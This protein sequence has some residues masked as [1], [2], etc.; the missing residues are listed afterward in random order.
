MK[1]DK[2]QDT[3][4]TTPTPHHALVHMSEASSVFLALNL[5]FISLSYKE[6]TKHKQNNKDEM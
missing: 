3:R 1:Q 5:L 4:K 6:Q 2:Q